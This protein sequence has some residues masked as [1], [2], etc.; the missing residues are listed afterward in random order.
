MS[1]R[2]LFAAAVAAFVAAVPA[3]AHEAKVGTIE[4]SDLW[5]RATPPKAPTGAGFMTI[6]NEGKDADRLVAA[7]SP[8]ADQTQIHEMTTKDGVMTMHEVEGGLEIPAGGSVTLA[9]GGYHIMF[10]G[11]KEGFVDG[12][13]VPVTLTFEKAGSVETFLHVRP[14]GAEGG[15]AHHDDMTHDDTK[16]DMK[17]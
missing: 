5:T 9:P 13:K 2:I 8:V 16:M 11:L 3:S 4:I 15:E 14:I 7:A 17:Q 12:G 6:A 1:M 10:M